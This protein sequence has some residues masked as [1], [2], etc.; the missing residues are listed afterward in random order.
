MSTGHLFDSAYCLH[1]TLALLHFVW[2]GALIA[3]G[4]VLAAWLLGRV[5]P[6]RRCRIYV[7]ALVLMLLCLPLTLGVVIKWSPGREPP[8]ADPGP[9]VSSVAEIEM[10]G[11][12]WRGLSLGPSEVGTQPEPVSVPNRVPPTASG[13]LPDSD[14][15]VVWPSMRVGLYT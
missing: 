11:A 3:G 2:Q 7:T 5:S 13:T 1:L 9:G 12:P 6:E 15:P 8:V 14:T 4:S 10:D